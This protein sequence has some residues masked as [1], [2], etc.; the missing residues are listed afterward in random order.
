MVAG[1]ERIR[2]QLDVPAHFP[3]DVES[4]VDDVVASGPRTPSGSP[5]RWGCPDHPTLGS[6]KK[7]RRILRRVQGR[8]QA[9]G[10][11]HIRLPR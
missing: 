2:E 4:E 6:Q 7:S 5:F 10:R 11:G 1:F 8:P 3:P 9:T